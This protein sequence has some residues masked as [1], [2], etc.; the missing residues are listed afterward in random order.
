MLMATTLS[1]QDE[2]TLLLSDLINLYWTWTLN[3]I[4]SHQPLALHFN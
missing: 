2:T 1:G 4:Q 3:R